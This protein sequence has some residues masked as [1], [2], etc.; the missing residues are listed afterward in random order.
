MDGKDKKLVCHFASLENWT[1]LFVWPTCVDSWCVFFC[2]TSWTEPFVTFN[3]RTV[4]QIRMTQSRE[5]SNKLHVAH[6][7]IARRT[8]SYSVG[9]RPRKMSF[10]KSTSQRAK[11]CHRVTPIGIR[12][13]IVVAGHIDLFSFEVLTQTQCMFI[14]PGKTHV[15]WSSRASCLPFLLKPC[16][17][18]KTKTSNTVLPAGVVVR[19]WHTTIPTAGSGWLHSKWHEP[20]QKKPPRHVLCFLFRLH[21][22]S[23]S[24]DRD[25][26]KA[27]VRWPLGASQT[28][29]CK[30]L[31]RRL[32]IVFSCCRAQSHDEQ[33]TQ[34]AYLGGC[35][36]GNWR[37][38]RC[39]FIRII[40]WRCLIHR[41]GPQDNPDLGCDQTRDEP[42]I[43]SWTFVL[44]TSVRT[45]MSHDDRA[46]VSQCARCGGFCESVFHQYR[47]L[48]RTM[49]KSTR[50]SYRHSMIYCASRRCS[51]VRWATVKGAWCRC[52]TSPVPRVSSSGSWP[53]TPRLRGASPAVSDDRDGA[54]KINVT[55]EMQPPHPKCPWFSLWV[56]ATMPDS[57]EISVG[58]T[59]TGSAKRGLAWETAHGW[60]WTAP[61]IWSPR[62][63]IPKW[64]SSQKWISARGSR[65][66]KPFVKTFSCCWSA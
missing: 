61:V 2:G 41:G 11:F 28:F 57:T 65:S 55:A 32:T 4:R 58:V 36:R 63:L 22:A 24:P 14:Q 59:G 66:T 48:A 21:G 16:V 20:A 25:G 31:T 35:R 50:S 13:M 30:V 3:I 39:I 53:T 15:I 37:T 7:R 27:H 33:N 46:R 10:S 60:S 52:G 49:G 9:T 45:C 62:W 44:L 12:V 17:P 47:R 38:R 6:I 56:I 8:I 5:C 19:M 23:T 54:M 26:A 51:S 18:S 40:S 34:C 43:L 1:M 42:L 64:S 29:V